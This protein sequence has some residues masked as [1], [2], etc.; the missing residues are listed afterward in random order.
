M[1]SSLFIQTGPAAGGW[2]VYPPLSA[3]GAGITRIQ[4]WG[5]ISG[6]PVWQCWLRTFGWFELYR[7]HIK[8]AYE[9]YEHDKTAI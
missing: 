3:L 2:T 9:G 5:W 8:Y 6:S 7:H 1:M 4:N